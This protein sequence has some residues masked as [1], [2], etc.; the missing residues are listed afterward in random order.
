MIYCGSV[1]DKK[2]PKSRGSYDDSC[3]RGL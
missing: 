1:I 3:S 2:W